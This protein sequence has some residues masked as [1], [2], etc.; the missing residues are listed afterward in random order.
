[1]SGI[2][3]APNQLDAMAAWSGEAER[4][5]VRALNFA[6]AAGTQRS[7]NLSLMSGARVGA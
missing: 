2:G 6:A 3:R 5:L 4:L 7:T 1:M